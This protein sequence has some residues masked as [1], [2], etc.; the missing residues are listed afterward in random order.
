MRQQWENICKNSTKE[1][2][3]D[4]RYLCELHFDNSCFNPER[5]LKPD[6]V[7]RPCRKYFI[8]CLYNIIS[9]L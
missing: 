4:Q 5:L 2:D 8:K 9:Y 6:A 3:Q 1:N 7:P